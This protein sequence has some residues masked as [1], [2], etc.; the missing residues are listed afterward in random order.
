MYYEEIETKKAAKEAHDNNQRANAA[1][2]LR[3]LAEKRKERKMKEQQRG[4]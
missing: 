2:R 4:N 3:K 1:T